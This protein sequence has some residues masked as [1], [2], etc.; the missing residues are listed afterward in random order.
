MVV[1]T[2]RRFYSRVEVLR[3]F[4]LVGFVLCGLVLFGIGRGR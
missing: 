2:R 3:V 4:Y 1:G